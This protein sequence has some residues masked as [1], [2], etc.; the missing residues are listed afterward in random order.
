MLIDQITQVIGRTPGLTATQ[1]AT[2]IFGDAGYYQ[3]VIGICQVLAATSVVK[4]HGGGG[5][6]DPFT[7]H[8]KTPSA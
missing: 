4:R 2:A 5:P 6:G 1:I 7:Y 3:R 8:L